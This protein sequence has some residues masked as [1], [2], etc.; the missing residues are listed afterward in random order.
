MERTSELSGKF[1]WPQ[2]CVAGIIE[3]K[4]EGSHKIWLN[5]DRENS[6][7]LKTETP[8]FEEAEE[9][10]TTRIINKH[11]ST[12]NFQVLQTSGKGETFKTRTENNLLKKDQE[13]TEMTR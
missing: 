12:C 11:T 9:I 13:Y 1:F 3:W 10:P 7:L 4:G 8:Q 5:N 6:N 2:I